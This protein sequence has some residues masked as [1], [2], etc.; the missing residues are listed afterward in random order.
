MRG[1][2]SPHSVCNLAPCAGVGVLSDVVQISIFVWQSFLNWFQRKDMI[3]P[4]FVS[5]QFWFVIWNNV[6]WSSVMFKDVE[7]PSPVNPKSWHRMSNTFLTQKGLWNSYQG[8]NAISTF[9]NL[10]PPRNVFPLLFS[11]SFENAF[12][13][14]INLSKCSRLS[15]S[16]VLTSTP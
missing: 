7:S 3:I 8:I 6:L 1:Y 12:K 16:S 2:S 11:I 14:S 15:F 10:P 5:T 13:P 4:I 9:D